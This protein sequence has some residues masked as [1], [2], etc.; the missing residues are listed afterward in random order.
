MPAPALTAGRVLEVVRPGQVVRL[1]LTSAQVTVF[2]DAD[3]RV[4]LDVLRHLLGARAFLAGPTAVDVFPLTEGMFQAVAAARGHVVGIKRIRGLIRRAEASGVIERRASY[5]QPY[6]RGGGGGAYRVPLYGLG[7][8][9]AKS[10]R[11][12]G[13]R[14]QVKR[15]VKPPFWEHPLFGDLH[16]LPPPGHGVRA[17]RRMARKW[18]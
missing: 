18:S 13:R 3:G 9:P 7:A 11:P 16:G 8:R 15:D 10:K 12:V 6:R 4:F 17:L 1:T 5:R 14:P 2:R